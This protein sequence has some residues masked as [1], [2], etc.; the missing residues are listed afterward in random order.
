MIAL[1]SG[2]TACSMSAGSMLNVSGR[3]STKRGGAPV[4]RL[5][6]ARATNAEGVGGGNHLVAGADS[7]RQQRQVKR[8]RAGRDG[9]GKITRCYFGK[10]LFQFGHFWP[11]GDDAAVQH[12]AQESEFFFAELRFGDRNHVWG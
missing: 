9:D 10:F 6:L 12:F 7:V 2:V 5:P 3:M 1:V 11:L 4:Q 8:R